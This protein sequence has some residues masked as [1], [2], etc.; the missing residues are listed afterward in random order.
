MFTVAQLKSAPKEQKTTFEAVLLVRKLAM[1]KARN[2][3][4][5]LTVELGDKTGLFHTVCFENSANFELFNAIGEG[6]VVRVTGNTDYY[7]NR[8]SP[9]LQTIAVVPEEEV[10][11]WSESLVESAPEDLDDLW[12]EL[13]GFIKSIEHKE[14]RETVQVA[15]D[16]LGETFKGMPGAIAMHHAY[17]GGLMEHTVRMARAAKVLLPLYP[18]VP[19][20]LALSGIILHDIGKALEYTGPW[21]TRKTREGTLNG[22]VVLGYRLARRAAIRAKLSAD[23]TERLEHIILSHQGEP[24]WGAAVRAATPE[25]V[26]VSMVDNLDAK[27]GMVQHSL[28]ATAQE[29]EFS[30]YVPGLMSPLL[31]RP[32]ELSLPP[33]QEEVAENEELWPVNPPGLKLD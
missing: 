9:T 28:R 17:R 6:Q 31:T 7:Q 14:L 33:V 21:A 5:F 22:H 23:L 1:K 3:S 15:I 2:N 12:N 19:A 26:F 24:E 30:E 8:F 29:E 32:S 11:K 25:A 18:E 16:D 27:M 20:D 10:I 4:Q 13:H